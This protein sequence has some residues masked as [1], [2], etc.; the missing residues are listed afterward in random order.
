MEILIGFIVLAIIIRLIAGSMDSD[1]VKEDIESKGGKLISKEWTPFGKG[2]FGEKNDRIYEVIYI[3]KDGNKHKAFVKTS[4]FSGV[5]YSSDEII[6]YSNDKQN[7]SE[8]DTDLKKENEKL[9]REIE[10]LK[11]KNI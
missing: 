10:E 5:Y 8:L 1:R 11:K 3:D 6:E 7:T 9:K 2:W 4:S